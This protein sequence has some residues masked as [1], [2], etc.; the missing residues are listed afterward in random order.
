M[1]ILII[2]DA[3][4]PQVNGVV[5]TYEY[6]NKELANR[7][8]DIKV[9]SPSDFKGV[10]PMPGYKEIQ[11]A[12]APYKKLCRLIK[13]YN[14]DAIHIA[15]E[16]PIG[17]ASRKYCLKNNIKFTTSYHS[18]FPDYFA[19]RASRR[20]PFLYNFFRHVGVQIIKNF[21]APSSSMLVTTKSMSDELKGWGIKTPINK[22][23]RGLDHQIFHL[24]PKNLFRDLKQPIALY[25][26]R[27]AVEKNIEEFLDMPWH[28]SK[29]VV[30]H[31]P[32]ENKL[33]KKYPNVV[34]TGKKTGK[35]LADHYRSSDIFIFPSKTDTFGLVLIEALACGL[36][37]AAHDVIGPRD[38]II[39]DTLGYLHEDLSIAAMKA[40]KTGS[41]K[42]RNQYVRENYT[43]EK[44]CD[45]FL[46]A[47]KKVLN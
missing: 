29:V 41:A 27:L 10:M 42:Q 37:V 8:H 33:R 21:H 15:T 40:L 1:K 5:R 17:T 14:P 7:G 13:G 26:G 34:F 4:H 32:D 24:G 47:T 28:G 23:T 46:E 2:S 45:Q 6:L 19:K 44:A 30:G 16:G 9:I 3:W 35:E 38:V 11:L 12:V 39:N 43:W 36:P 25:V 18:Q 31:G 22:F 20:T